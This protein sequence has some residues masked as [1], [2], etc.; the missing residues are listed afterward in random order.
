MHFLL[1][2]EANERSEEST[3]SNKSDT[4]EKD[5]AKSEITDQPEDAG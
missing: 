4:A 2:A 1:E 5:F 3:N